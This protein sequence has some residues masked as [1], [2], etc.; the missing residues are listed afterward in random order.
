MRHVL[1]KC[2]NQSLV[3]NII[4]TNNRGGMKNDRC[5]YKAL[6]R[7]EANCWETSENDLWNLIFKNDF[8]ILHIILLKDF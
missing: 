4:T 2:K 1:W 3:K 5:E 7:I 8:W 6:L